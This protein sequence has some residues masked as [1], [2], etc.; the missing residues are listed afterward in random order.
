MRGGRTG[1][2]GLHRLRV[3]QEVVT[4]SKVDGLLLV[5]GIDGNFDKATAQALSYL[6]EGKSGHEVFETSMVGHDLEDVV[7]LVTR[8]SF[9]CY[10]PTRAHDSIV[11]LLA[12]G[13]EHSQIFKPH[14]AEEQDT[15]ILEEYKIGSF[16]QMVKDLRVVGLPCKDM[17][18]ESWPLIQSYGIEGVGRSGFFTMNFK[19][20]SLFESIQRV[21]HQLD[22][23]AFTRMARGT[24]YMFTKHFSEVMS[25]LDRESLHNLV[26]LE[27]SDLLEPFAD[28]YSCGIARKGDTRIPSLFRPRLLAGHHTSKL[29]STKDESLPLRQP[30]EEPPLHFILELADPKTVLAC[31]RT[32]FLSSARLREGGFYPTDEDLYEIDDFQG[33]KNRWS[34]SDVLY[35][36]RAYACLIDAGAAAMEFF[37]TS[38]NASFEDVEDVASKTFANALAARKVKPLPLKFHLEEVDIAGNVFPPKVG[39][40]RLKRFKMST[41]GL[42]SQ[43]S[44]EALL[45]SIAYGETFLDSPASVRNYEVLSSAVPLVQSWPTLQAEMIIQKYMSKMLKKI[46]DDSMISSSESSRNEV[47]SYLGELVVDG[48]EQF[49]VLAPNRYQHSIS[50]EIFLFQKGFAFFSPNC[51]PIVVNLEKDVKSFERFAP[52]QNKDILL[53]ELQDASLTGFEREDNTIGLPLSTL[54]PS[55]LRYFNQRVWP[56]WM[57]ILPQKVAKQSSFAEELWELHQY[58]CSLRGKDYPALMLPDQGCEDLAFHLDTKVRETPT[59]PMAV[60]GKDSIPLVLLVGIPGS[61]HEALAG[62][63]VKKASQ[64]YDWTLVKQDPSTLLAG[65]QEDKLGEALSVRKG[66]SGKRKGLLLPCPGFRGASFY[67]DLLSRTEHL[68]SGACHVHS[69]VACVHTQNFVRDGRSLYC[70]G[71][72]EQL[73]G[74]LVQTVAIFGDEDQAPSLRRILRA[75]LPGAKLVNSEGVAGDGL[76]KPLLETPATSEASSMSSSAGHE[77]IFARTMCTILEDEEGLK[78]VLQQEL[79]KSA[80]VLGAAPSLQDDLGEKKAALLWAKAVFTCPHSNSPKELSVFGKQVRITKSNSERVCS[81]ATSPEVQWVFVGV[82]I[83]EEYAKRLISKCV[84]E[85]RVTK[86][87]R[88]PKDLKASEKEII[89]KEHALDPLPDGYRFTGSSFVDCFGDHRDLHPDFE[90]HAKLFLEKEREETRRYN[91]EIERYNSQLHGL[92][93]KIIHKI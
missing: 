76:I 36:Y 1:K 18:V 87:L 55:A 54:E 73:S 6:L 44:D 31:A 80:G 74:D 57:E 77:V 17:N 90:E 58:T 65:P 49:T 21:Y 53:F 3:L 16:V 24:L 2:G 7:F 12:C 26:E 9:R 86:G 22:G 84:Q 69:V 40:K 72:F 93:V 43:G 15:D 34:P 62:L 64:E 27:E 39:S 10:C 61:G 23:Q 47:T 8:D 50:G 89:K 91:E 33:I 83:T 68:Q 14:E 11:D 48:S 85:K 29:D 25:L 30:G 71:L 75:R 79:D 37:S 82:N 78:K 46:S 42:K 45:G 20:Q 66:D 92:D 4:Q 56:L 63:L 35:L 28:Y 81:P 70:E 13:I 41:S 32:Y 59:S 19:T 38:S 52:D 88:E 51:L 5:A 60:R 67:L